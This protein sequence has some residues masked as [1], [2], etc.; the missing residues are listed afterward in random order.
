MINK[1]QPLKIAPSLN[2]CLSAEELIA[3]AG[4]QLSGAET[5]RIKQ[6]LKSCEFC[7]EAF[8]GASLFPD[9][10][11][12]PDRLRDIRKA[13]HREAISRK[14]ALQNRKI[15]YA[16][17]AIFLLAMV[18]VFYLLTTQGFSD[19]IF[20]DFFEPYPN[21]IPIIRSQQNVSSLQL[22]MQQYELGNYR[23]SLSLLEE[24]LAIKP[25]NTD[26]LFYAGIC[27]LVQNEPGLATQYF[28]I[29]AKE[30]ASNFHQ[31]SMWYLALA[32]LKNKNLVNA[33][34]I[35]INIVKSGNEYSQKSQQILS[36]LESKK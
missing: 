1:Q 3:I 36:K 16:A 8:D 10:D 22:A 20:A 34:Q 15:Y 26:G 27:C 32:H 30:P 28:S 11:N 9:N 19:E 2:E 12:A 17:A 29:L 21:T 25:K 33:K 5:E 23:G 24:H 31:Q 14:Q 18:S 4:D 7:S 13:I 35:F 6:H